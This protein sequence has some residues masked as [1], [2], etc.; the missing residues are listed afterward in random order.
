M[1]SPSCDYA[2]DEKFEVERNTQ[3]ITRQAYMPVPDIEEFV[4]SPVTAHGPAGD[5]EA[6]LLARVC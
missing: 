4:T 2:C 1:D 3:C 5:D 6:L